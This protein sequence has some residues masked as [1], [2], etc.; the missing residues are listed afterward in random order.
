MSFEWHISTRHDPDNISSGGRKVILDGM[1]E[2]GK[3]VNDNQKWILGFEDTFYQCPKGD[4]KVII[5]IMEY[6]P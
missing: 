5:T 1:V 2:S 3:L 6:E 4:D